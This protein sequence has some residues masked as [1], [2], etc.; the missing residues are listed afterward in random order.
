MKAA[1]DTS[2]KEAVRRARVAEDVDNGNVTPMGWATG[3]N[4]G[5]ETVNLVRVREV[6]KREFAPY[7][8]DEERD[9]H[10]Q[11]SGANLYKGLP[12]RHRVYPI[13]HIGRHVRAM[14]LQTDT[15]MKKKIKAVITKN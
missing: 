5:I 10:P 3:E 4:G 9:D 11:G 7:N 6:L 1:R 8:D 13:P 2:P 12:T 14:G 15:S